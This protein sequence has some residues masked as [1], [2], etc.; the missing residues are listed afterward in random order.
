MTDAQNGAPHGPAPDEPKYWLDHKAN[1][2]KLL[3]GFY[4]VCAI[5]FVI[6]IFVPKHGLLAI[7]H[8]FG[9]YAIYGFVGCS[10]VILGAKLLRILVMRSEGYYDR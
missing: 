4:V 1:V 9:F 3:R 10:A 7:E 5:L 6:D 8:T 2:D